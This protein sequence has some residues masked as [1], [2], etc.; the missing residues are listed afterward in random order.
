VVADKMVPALATQAA[1]EAAHNFAGLY[2]ASD[3][4]STL[5]LSVDTSGTSAPGLV[6]SSWISNGTDVLSW[7]GRLSGA[8]PYRLVSSITPTKISTAGN[9][10]KVAFRMVNAVDAP[11][12]DKSLR[13]ELFTR[14][15]IA[16]ADWE[17]VDTLTYYGIGLSLF[18]MDIGCDGRAVSV[19]PAAYRT[20]LARST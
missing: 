18:V 16:D 8:G 19:T 10:R 14:S 11:S 6:I 3:Q 5:T 1:A 17:N 2:T 13:T 4:N 20:K 15:G 9:T 12:S 7:L